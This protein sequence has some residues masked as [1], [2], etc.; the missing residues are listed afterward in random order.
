[1]DQPDYLILV[2]SSDAQTVLC[3]PLGPAAYSMVHTVPGNPRSDLIVEFDKGAYGW[4]SIDLSERGKETPGTGTF[5]ARADP[6][7]LAALTVPEVRIVVIREPYGDNPYIEME[8]P[9]E[10]GDLDYDA[11]RDGTDGPGIVTVT[12]ADDQSSLAYRLVYPNPA[13]AATG[14]TTTTAYTISN[15][16]AEDAARTL[17]NVNAAAG[18][19]PNRRYPELTLGV[20]AGVGTPIS[21][22]FVRSTTLTDALRE[23]LRL[24]GNLSMRT[25]QGADNI[26]RF[27]V[28][29]PRDLTDTVWF[30]RALGNIR[31]L[32][33]NWGPPT[34][35]V[36]VVGDDTAG[37][38]RV[39]KERANT[40]ALAAGYRRKE[41][42]VDGRSA[43]NAA[44]LEQAG[45]EALAEAGP[46]AKVSLTAVESPSQRYREHIRIDD[47]VSVEV[48]DGYVVA[49]VVRGVDISVTPDKG[50]VVSLIIGEAGDAEIDLKAQELAKLRKRIA[51]LEGAG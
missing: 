35:T 32:G 9:F 23:I 21:T 29:A 46:T 24:G 15:V 42:W 28:Y 43:A 22:S 17:V 25:T 45:D 37:V 41:I 20:D 1:M 5:T 49:A 40:E 33:F 31:T 8:G 34:A 19:L 14:Q 38:G 26:V 30:S 51:Q 39:V 16:N 2:Q 7:L 18:A 6:A 3:D 47:I 12:F 50:E 44:E 13:Q 11:A 4:R 48:F 36:A 10:D 27:E